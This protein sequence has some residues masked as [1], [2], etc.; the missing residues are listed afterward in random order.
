[1]SLPSGRGPSRVVALDERT[2]EILA[3]RREASRPIRRGWLVRRVLVRRPHRAD[4]AFVTATLIFDDPATGHTVHR[5][6]DARLPPDL[7]LWVVVAKLYGLYDHDEERT[8]HS[9]DGRPV[10]LPSGHGGTWLFFAV[11]LGHATPTRGLP[12]SSSSGSSRSRSSPRAAPSPERSRAGT[13]PTYRTRSSSAPARS[14]S[15]WRTSSSASRVRHQPRRLRRRRAQGA[16][17][18]ARPRRCSAGPRSSRDSCRCSTSSA[19]SFAF[20]K[21]SHEETLDL[22]RSLK[23]LDIQIDIVPRFFEVIGTNVGIHTPRACRSS[24][25]RRS[26]SRARPS[27]SSARSTCRSPSSGWPARAALRRRRALDQARLAGAGLL[28]PGADGSRRPDVPRSSSSA[29]WSPTP[30]RGSDELALSTSTLERRR[31]AHVQDPERPARH[32]RRARGSGA[33]RST[34][35]RSS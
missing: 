20:S 4:G 25:C 14:G 19:S 12:R 7:P 26:G 35:C 32:A 1:M 5:D 11:D 24:G 10:R 16:P 9:T 29:R 17:V 18:E 33:T 30:T 21:D 2:L 8:D 28:P 13:L 3:R 27:S 15:S 31:P 23:D 22:I 6:R 34:S